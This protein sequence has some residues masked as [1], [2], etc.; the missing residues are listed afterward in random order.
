MLDLP[1]DIVVHFMNKMRLDI[2]ESS[3]DTSV[4]YAGMD[5]DSFIAFLKTNFDKYLAAGEKSLNIF[6]G[7]KEGN[8]NIF[9]GFESEKLGE[10]LPLLVEAYEDNLTAIAIVNMDG[11]I[12]T[13]NVR[14]KL[15]I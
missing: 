3:I 7:K 2:I 13:G 5:Y 12:K 10:V 6:I 11:F 15:V 14:S 4:T 8:N 9:Y 1:L